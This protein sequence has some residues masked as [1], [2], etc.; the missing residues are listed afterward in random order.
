MKIIKRKISLSASII[1]GIVSMLVL[2]SILVSVVGSIGY[3]EALKKEYA[4]S[5]YRMADTAAAIVDGDNLGKYLEEGENEEY[6][7]HKELLELY[8]KKIYVSLIYVIVVDRSDYGRFQSLYNTVCNEVDDTDYEEWELGHFR[9]TTNDDYRNKYK[10]IYEDGSVYETVYRLHITDGKK[11]HITT[12]VPVKNSKDEVVGI[13]CVQRPISA[14][15]RQLLKYL[16]TIAALVTLF[17]AVA[18]IIV[19]KHNKKHFVVPIKSITD[20]ASRFAQGDLEPHKFGDISSIEEISELASSIEKMGADM[21]EYIKN[22]T[23]ITGERERIAA[24]LSIA[25]TIQENS[26]PNTFPA[27][28]ERSDFDIYAYMTPAKEVGGDFYNFFLV[29]DDHIALLIAD[30]SG[31]GIPAALFMM[32]SNILIS[33]GVSA[34]NSPAE[35]LTFVNNR[36]CSHNKAE[37]FVTVWLGILELSSGKIIAANAGHDDPAVYRSNGYFEMQTNKH[38]LV[39]GAMPGVEYNNYEIQLSTGDKLF[40]YTDGVPEATDKDNNLFT[41]NGMLCALN[42]YKEKTPKEI[43]EGVKSEVDL[44]VGDAPQFDDLTMLCIELK[45]KNTALIIEAEN[46]NLHKVIEYVDRVLEENN[47]SMKDQ[48]KID[49]AVEEIFVN[50]ANYAYGDKTGMAEIS[51]ECSDSVLTIVFKDGGVQYNPLEKKDPDTTLSADER[52]I[53]GLGIFLVK[54]NM[55]SVSYEYKDSKNILTMK[56]KIN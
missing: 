4:E 2:F 15:R 20:E 52:E 7:R 1:N 41:I 49:L 39:I 40:L 42:K 53:G 21:K 32:V 8:C 14:F 28:P 5:T 13:L 26:V 38:S 54:K 46:D 47:C 11:Q 25:G 19:L 51:A 30:V 31:K 45:E 37:M 17:S 18:A 35:V 55:D 34:G 44:F 27:F 23:A 12:L 6:R 22:L 43:L 29:D 33:E 56:K 3:A 24:E 48:M 10:K 36:I 50:I 16:T 9:D